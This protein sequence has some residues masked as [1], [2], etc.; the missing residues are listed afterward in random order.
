MQDVQ[1]STVCSVAH[2]S[3]FAVDLKVSAADCG[4]NVKKR[5]ESLVNLKCG[6]HTIQRVGFDKGTNMLHY[7]IR[8]WRIVRTDNPRAILLAQLKMYV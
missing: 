6:V 3:G 7:V 8:C 2:D 4:A 5:I 1:P